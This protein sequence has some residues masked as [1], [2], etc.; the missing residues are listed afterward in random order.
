LKTVS[1][2]GAQF[3][4]LAIW[5]HGC[6]GGG[7]NNAANAPP[8]VPVT[9]ALQGTVT[10]DLV[11]AVAGR[12][13]DYAQTA[14]RPARG[15]TVEAVS[16][17][18]V[19]ASAATDSAGHYSFTVASNADV[20]LRVRA[21]MVRQG[22]PSW[23]FRVVDNVNSD[24]LYVL[25]GAVFNTGTAD[26]T[27]SLHAASGWTGSAYTAA[28][29]AAP[30][31]ILDV[32]YDSVQVVL[33]AVP[34]T[35][36]PPLQMKWSTGNVPVSGSGPGEI[37][38]SRFVAGVGIE[39]VGAADQDTDEY[40]RHVIAHE[41]G[42][43][44]ER[45]FS[46][47]DS[48]GGAHSITDQVDMRVAFSEGWASTFAAVATGE[49]IYVD[50]FG[51]GQ[52]RNF[53]FDLEQSP[54]RRNP[55]PGWFNEEAVQ[56]LLY[57][58]YDNGR[59]VA[60]GTLTLDD[61]ALGFGPLFDVMINGQR[62]TL[63]LTSI[64]SLV[65]TL[66]KARPADAPLIDQLTTAQGMRPVADEYGATE[67]NFGAPTKRT[68]QEVGADFHSVYDTVAVN[69]P[70]V[71]VCSLDDFTSAA[72]G[73]GNKLASRRFVRFAVTTPGPHVVTA[74]AIAPLLGV[75]DPDL[76][77]HTPDGSVLSSTGP[78]QCTINTPQDCVESFT[79]TLAAGEHVLEV[80]EWTNTND[81]TDQYPPIGRTCFDVTVTR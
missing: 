13:L 42:H 27:R 36:F 43:Y 53:S 19:V 21:E 60:P 29:S 70:A 66:K 67:T 32:V 73:A 14:E 48:I 7:G 15:V 78:P 54:N 35:A 52:A 81:T 64:F 11:P 2:R 63:A 46:R 76:K 31:A 8:P 38:S 40:D 1:W 65:D 62:Q 72:T 16:A 34:T 3:A 26:L 49:P 12:G 80:Y 9:V 5:L 44:L 47:S 50:T 41:W 57:D 77:L 4:A 22:S 45:A 33:G 28:R 51:A 20:A 23:D 68:P 59:D 6:G 56:S 75:A 79:P 61:I 24:A 58:L 17:G 25:A 37:G 74:R 39:L 69:G 71:N 18:A 55:N 30:F 10:F